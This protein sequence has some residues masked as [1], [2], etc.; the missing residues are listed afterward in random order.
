ML[1]ESEFFR[2]VVAITPELKESE[3]FFVC[4]GCINTFVTVYLEDGVRKGLYRGLSINYLRVIPQV[5]V[6]FS[7]YELTKQF[8]SSDM[9]TERSE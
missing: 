1:K 7:V 2:V 4:S 3:F 9:T 8:L 6:M 5:A